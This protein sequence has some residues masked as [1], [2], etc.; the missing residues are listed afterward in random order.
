MSRKGLKLKPMNNEKVLR[1]KCVVQ[2]NLNCKKIVKGFM[3]LIDK[4]SRYDL[5]TSI[6]KLHKNAC[7]SKYDL[8]RGPIPSNC[9]QFFTI[10][11]SWL[12]LLRKFVLIFLRILTENIKKLSL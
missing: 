5:F 6:S 11:I 12:I 3:G 1:I 9:T 8:L 2:N 7:V 10:F 4:L